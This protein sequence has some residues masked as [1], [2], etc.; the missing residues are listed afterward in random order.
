MARTQVKKSGLSTGIRIAIAFGIALILALFIGF[1]EFQYSGIGTYY[2]IGYRVLFPLLAVVLSFGGTCF[3]QYLSCN[4]VEWLLQFGR[5]FIILIPL[6]LAHLI[7]YFD[8][9]R[10][11]IE[12]MMQ[13]QSK[14]FQRAMATSF[15]VFWAALYGQASVNSLSQTCPK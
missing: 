14:Q 9:L 11:P 5:S 4:E 12:G 1:F 2:L 13:L 10:W 3:I 6:I 7:L 8:R 15:Y